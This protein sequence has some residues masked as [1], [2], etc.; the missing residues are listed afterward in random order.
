MVDLKFEGSRRDLWRGEDFKNSGGSSLFLS[1]RTK[2]YIKKM[3]VEASFW[4][5]IRQSLNDNQL[6][7]NMQVTTDLTFYF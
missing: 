2:L 7:K 4:S 5:P 1:C 6:Q 3:A